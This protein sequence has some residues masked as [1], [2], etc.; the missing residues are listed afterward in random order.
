MSLGKDR[1]FWGEIYCAKS[2]ELAQKNPGSIPPKQNNPRIQ[3]DPITIGFNIKLTLENGLILIPIAIG[4]SLLTVNCQ[5]YLS[6]FFTTRDQL[7]ASPA[8]T[9]IM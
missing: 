4:S 1:K 6:Q 9:F 7:T 2:G 5:L 8:V 3:I